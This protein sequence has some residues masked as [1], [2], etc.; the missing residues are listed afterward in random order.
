MS[1][2]QL[3]TWLEATTTGKR[4]LKAGLPETWRVG[5]KT[6]PAYVEGMANK[7]ND[8]AVALPDAGGELL[9]IAAYF[10]VDGAYP[11]IRPEDED[12]LRQVAASTLDWLGG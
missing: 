2:P 10:E 4:R 1:Q 6:G 11:R 5:N 7:Y 9:I 8:V 12:V 3:R